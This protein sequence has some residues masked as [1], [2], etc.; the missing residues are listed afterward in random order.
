MQQQ[1]IWHSGI[2]G[3]SFSAEEGRILI[4]RKTLEALGKPSHYRFLYNAHAHEIA[5]QA[6]NAEEAGSHRVGKLDE[7]SS[8]EIKCKA[9]VQMIY[10]DA[11][12]NRRCSYRLTGR[13]FPNQRLVSFQIDDAAPIEYGRVLPSDV[14]PTF[15]LC[16]AEGVQAQNNPTPAEKADSGEV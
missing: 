3:M 4:F 12:W 1:K 2:L 14:S 11:G 6:C 5:V 8:C 9:F 16:R 7:T 13:S 15:A 10:K